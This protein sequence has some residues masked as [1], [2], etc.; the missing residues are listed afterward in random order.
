M[1]A[2]DPRPWSL[3]DRNLVDSTEWR[4]AIE[5]VDEAVVEHLR[6]IG[7]DEAHYGARIGFGKLKWCGNAC[8]PT[9]FAQATSWHCMQCLSVSTPELGPKQKS[10]VCFRYLEEELQR[11]YRDAAPSTLTVLQ[12]RCELVAAELA[13]AEQNLASANDVPA[14]R[15]A[16]QRACLL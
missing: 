13:T 2:C 8:V 5:A 3:Q 6:D 1:S 11:R 16:G 15:K 4:R 10:I 9:C 14:L 7:F 12:Q